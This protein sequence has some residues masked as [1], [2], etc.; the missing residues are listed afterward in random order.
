MEFDPGFAIHMEE[1]TL[2]FSYGDG[3]FG[4]I[5][6]KRKVCHSGRRR[7]GRSAWRCAG[8]AARQCR[9]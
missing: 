7:P 4:P 8:R 6:E 9:G 1:E 5:C 2:T 3:A